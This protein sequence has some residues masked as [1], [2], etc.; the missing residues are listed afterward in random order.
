MAATSSKDG[1][2]QT[3][4]AF[5]VREKLS[6]NSRWKL[7]ESVQGRLYKPQGQGDPPLGGAH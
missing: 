4:T 5:C 7:L 3:R 2:T 1:V 6:Q